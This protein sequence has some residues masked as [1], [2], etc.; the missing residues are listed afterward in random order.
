[1]E[2][3]KVVEKL[4]NGS[5]TSCFIEHPKMTYAIGVKT[6]PPENCGPLAAFETLKDAKEF[7]N[8]RSSFRIYKCEIEESNE[9][10]LWNGYI[11]REDWTLPAGTIFCDSITLLSEI[12]D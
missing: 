8:S 5:L 10:A 6:V 3:Y 4:S 2:A 7:F 9:R 12:S 11:R 1:M